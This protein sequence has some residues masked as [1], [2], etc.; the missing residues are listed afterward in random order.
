[1]LSGYH[2]TAK[3]VSKAKRNQAVKLS[4]A[5]HFAWYLRMS[6]VIK[7]S[8]AQSSAVAAITYPKLQSEKRAAIEKP[9]M[10]EANRQ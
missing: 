5:S 4:R 9:Q 8:A 6:Q 7:G 2:G 10:R 3:Q 1:M